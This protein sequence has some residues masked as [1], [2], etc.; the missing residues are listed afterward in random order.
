VLSFKKG[1]EGLH[2]IRKQGKK[3][4]IEVHKKLFAFFF[5]V[6]VVDQALYVFKL[7]GDQLIVY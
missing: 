2:K 1:I 5:K 6:D 3:G 7:P 4:F